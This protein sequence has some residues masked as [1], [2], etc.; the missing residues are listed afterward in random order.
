MLHLYTFLISH[1]SEKVRFA[2]DLAGIRYEER[3]LLPGLHVRTIRKLAR[4]TSVPVLVHDGKAV[5]GSSAILD[6]AEAHLGVALVPR[7]PVEAERSRELEAL[8]DLAFGLGTQTI[9][10]DVLLREPRATIELWAQRRSIAI[11]ALYRVAFPLIAPRVRA[12]YRATPEGVAEAKDRF[13]RALDETDRALEGRRY[14]S[15]DAL[16]RADIAVAALLAPICKPK[17][18]VVEWPERGPDELEAFASAIR[19]RPTIEHV[20]RVYREHRATS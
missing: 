10:Y 4:A 11:R 17:E 2:L 18:H 19:E 15:G 16:G 9:C 6:Y 1:F 3:T 12:M 13:L 14:L 20:L 5:Q 8:A 7:D